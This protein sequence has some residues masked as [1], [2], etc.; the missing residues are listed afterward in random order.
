M[1]DSMKPRHSPRTF[2]QPRAAA[3]AGRASSPWL[4]TCGL[5]APA[6]SASGFEMRD[7]F[8][9]SAGPVVL[10]PRMAV[11]SS[12]SDNIFYLPSDSPLA[13]FG[14]IESRDDFSFILSPGLNV[15]LG[16]PDGDHRIDFN[17]RYDQILYVENTQAD[18]GNYNFELNA[19]TKGARLSYDCRNSLQYLNSIITG[20]TATIEGIP[21]PSGNLER[22]F[23]DLD[24]DF[25]Y[26]LSPKT[27]FLLGGLFRLRDYPGAELSS[28]TY[29]NSQEW[30]ADG[31][32][33]YSLSERIQLQ[34]RLNYGQVT[35]DPVSDLV[36]TPPRADA[37]G[38]TLRLTGNLTRKLTGRIW[39]G[40]E[41]RWFSNDEDDDGYPV[42]GVDLTQRFTEKNSLTLS[43]SRGGSVSA[44]ALTTSS[45]VRDV[46]SLGFKQ[47]LG[48]ANPWFVDLGVRYARTEY[49]T[50]DRELDNF[51]VSAGVSRMLRSWLSVFANY[52]Y[53]FGNRSNFDY[54]VNQVSLGLNLGY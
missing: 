18:S 4:T 27:R 30:R 50:T 19:T 43:Y 11:V 9:V 41:Y 35:R 34:A 37:M 12:Y 10:H 26:A 44:T 17:F 8:A 14:L 36:P 29:Y 2:R 5:L 25:S 22:Y 48:T 21:I 13:D 31:G 46:L 42:A 24:H 1:I 3:R 7:L 16:R 39:G 51:Q 28:R 6:F 54:D 52:T 47:Q 32:M 49:I 45:A 38:G 20:Y 33:G 53:E 15:R 40:Y 23:V